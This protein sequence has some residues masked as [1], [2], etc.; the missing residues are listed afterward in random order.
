MVIY[1]SVCK[2]QRAGEVRLS[3]YCV[4]RVFHVA[5]PGMYWTEC[6][7]FT[8]S[9]TQSIPTASLYDEKMDYR[10]NLCC[11][12]HPLQ[13]FSIRCW[14]DPTLIDEEFQFYRFVI[15]FLDVLH[16]FKADIEIGFPRR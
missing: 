4:E 2:I 6:Q 16:R 10:K 9:P 5:I 11:C 12:N 8:S 1:F 13:L 14:A 7:N 3:C 15:L